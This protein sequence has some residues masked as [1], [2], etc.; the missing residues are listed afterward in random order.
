VTTIARLVAQIGGDPT[1][2]TA[3]LKESAGEIA[4]FANTT[5]TNFAKIGA[6]VDL[7]KFANQ[8]LKTLKTT[9]TNDLAQIRADVFRGLLSPAEATQAGVEAGMAFNRGLTRS[10][11]RLEQTG[12]AGIAPLRNML[13]KELLASGVKGGAALAEGLAI[14]AP[15]VEAVAVAHGGRAGRSFAQAL[16]ATIHRHRSL[17]PVMAGLLI[18]QALGG[19]GDV[20]A[21]AD[22]QMLAA[23]KAAEKIL[24]Q[25][26]MLA[27]F[28]LPPIPGLIVAVVGGSIAAIIGL[29]VKA[30]EDLLEFTKT[31][32][33]E[34]DGLINSVD[35]LG[36]QRK[37]KVLEVG[38]P[39]AGKSLYKQ[40]AFK[41][42]KDEK[43]FFKSGLNDLLAMQKFDEAA[44]A[45]NTTAAS[46]D[47]MGR[48]LIEEA[49]AARKPLI[50]QA[51]AQRAI[52]VD[53]L[54]HPL[55]GD[56]GFGGQLPTI[57][58][59]AKTPKVGAE[60][61]DFEK[62]VRELLGLSK[63]LQTLDIPIFRVIDRLSE[64]YASILTQ[65]QGV[66][67]WSEQ[68]ISLRAVQA[69][70]QT[71]FSELVKGIGSINALKPQ[72]VGPHVPGAFDSN[73]R[74]PF[75][76]QQLPTGT[77]LDLGRPMS[78]T[79]VQFLRLVDNLKAA[80]GA[81]VRFG[82]GLG[83]A[84]A[85]TFNPIK[86]VT[87]VFG[88][89]AA[90][91]TPAEGAFHSLLIPLAQLSN[92][93]GSALKPVFDAMVP[94]VRELTPIFAVILQILAPL[95]EAFVPIIQAVLPIIRALLP[96]VKLMAISFTYVGQIMALFAGVALKIVT[97]LANAVGG[98]IKGIGSV[99]SHIPFMGGIGDSI[100][101]FGQDILNFANGTN[102]AGAYMFDAAG[103]F[104]DAREVLKAMDVTD[105][106]KGIKD[107]GLAAS[108]TAGLLNGPQGF[109]YEWLRYQSAL[110]TALPG[111]P[112]A[113]PTIGTPPHEPAVRSPSTL[114]A[115]STTSTV[116]VENIY[117]DARQLTRPELFDLVKKEA[118][119]VSL[120]KFGT[121]ARAAEALA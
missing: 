70:L 6:G 60:L 86:L 109:K 5:N 47:K 81:L 58:T 20:I 34:L 45:Y 25:F 21:S 57:K 8:S 71:Y 11:S 80:G 84:V 49:I 82:V 75:E 117:I 100:K 99:I 88:M 38:Q 42:E 112:G 95:F 30:K 64:K 113:R 59:E 17:I 106:S 7:T 24:E 36:L 16:T 9:L 51:L 3:A 69:E 116:N 62:G 55:G 85:D 118:Q 12:Q 101:A 26:A 13:S 35:Q 65:L 105:A 79:R 119:R 97:A 29:F 19:M 33:K 54:L 46:R 32:K 31:V 1:G 39:A 91:V 68:A 108:Q 83:Q 67:P 41:Y 2:L 63:S 52:I 56:T 90:A 43:G 50:A 93:I 15:A 28:L 103:K 73:I 10:I 92:V 27:S 22:H 37:L 110:A 14:A 72:I 89:I 4:D 48:R 107:L 114:G 74:R 94:V 87:G 115:A 40:D 78:E 76:G 23:G 120:S 98:A 53:A 77:N 44:L 102:E 66:D 104:A 61:K 111:G 18:S 121:T 96:V